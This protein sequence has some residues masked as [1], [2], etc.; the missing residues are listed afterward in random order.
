MKNGQYLL[1]CFCQESKPQL[2]VLQ[3]VHCSFILRVSL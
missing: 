1:L 3:E 2:P